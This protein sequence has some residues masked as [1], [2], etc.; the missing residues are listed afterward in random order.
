VLFET[1]FNILGGTFG[2]TTER[3]AKKL[4]WIGAGGRASYFNRCSTARMGR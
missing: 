1:T 3:L 4:R 2:L